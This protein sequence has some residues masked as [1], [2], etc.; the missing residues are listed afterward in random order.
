MH[1][2]RF[3]RDHEDKKIKIKCLQCGK[4][5]DYIRYAEYPDILAITPCIYCGYEYCEY[6]IT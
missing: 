2:I 4:K 6:L 3:I 5:Q 1:N